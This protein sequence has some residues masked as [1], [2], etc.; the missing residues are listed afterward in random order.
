MQSALK[1]GAATAVAAIQEVLSLG[2]AAAEGEKLVL[3]SAGTTRFEQ[4]RAGSAGIVERL[5]ADLP[6]EDQRTTRRILEIVTE[7]ANAELAGATQRPSIPIRR[8]QS[9][10]RTRR[11]SHR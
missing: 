1:V 7:R 3:T 9:S 4:I 2:L 5:Y 11:E 10:R 6:I 8:S